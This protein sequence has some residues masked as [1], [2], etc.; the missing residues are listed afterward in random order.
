MNPARM[1]KRISLY[2]SGLLSAAEVANA[3]L[4]DLVVNVNAAA[5]SQP[6]VAELPSEVRKELVDLLHDIRGAD[7]RWKPFRIGPSGDGLQ[8][9]PDPAIL[10]WVCAE[11]GVA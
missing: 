7:Y 2:S 3:I 11:F 5:E 4:M 10:Q 1:A 9:D 6:T 8:S